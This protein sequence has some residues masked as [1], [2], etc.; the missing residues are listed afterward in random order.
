MD[1]IALFSAGVVRKAVYA[2]WGRWDS[3]PPKHCAARRL[4]AEG[5]LAYRLLGRTVQWGNHGLVQLYVAV[6]T[7]M[8]E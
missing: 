3:T 5:A 1:G 2:C 8:V 6:T 7:W 4:C